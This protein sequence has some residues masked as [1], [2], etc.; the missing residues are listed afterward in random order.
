MQVPAL[1]LGDRHHSH[2]LLDQKALLEAQGAVH[3]GGKLEIVG[4][5]QRRHAGLAHEAQQLLEHALGGG[6]VEIAGRLVG[7]EETRPIG[8]GTGDGYALL[9]TAGK[10]RRTVIA[11]FGNAERVPGVGSRVPRPRLEIG[12]G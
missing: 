9:L 10:L 2:L 1:R 7:E 12:Q 6:R 5:D 4:G 3:A 11:A 8:D